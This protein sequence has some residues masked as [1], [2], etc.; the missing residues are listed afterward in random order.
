M[1]TLAAGKDAQSILVRLEAL[2]PHDAALWGRMNVHQMVCHVRDAMRVPMGELSVSDAEMRPLN[3]LVM[4]WGALYFPRRWP[5]DFPTRPE[6]DQ[7]RLNAPLRDFESDRQ[8]AIALLP[9]FCQANL[10]GMRHPSFGPITRAQWLR[11]GWLHTDHH[12]RQFGR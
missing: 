2:S 4:K 12:L 6:I 10:E 11:W 9:R 8:C 5:K 1:K 3:R 7:C